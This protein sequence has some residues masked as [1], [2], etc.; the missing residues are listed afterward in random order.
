MFSALARG[1]ISPARETVEPDR[2]VAA[3]TTASERRSTW[4]RE[5]GPVGA[6][7]DAAA[8]DRRRGS[9]GAVD[10]PVLRGGL[11]ATRVREGRRGDPGRGRPGE[12]DLARPPVPE[13]SGDEE[14]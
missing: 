2:R 14:H 12:P 1:A 5:L 7:T 6:L 9:R 11:R 10:L 4:S 3:R 8:A 13:G